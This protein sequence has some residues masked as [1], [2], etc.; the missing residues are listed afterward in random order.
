MSSLLAKIHARRAELIAAGK[1]SP[2]EQPEVERVYP[3]V[4]P[5]VPLR[6]DGQ[7]GYVYAQRPRMKPSRAREFRPPFVLSE[8]TRSGISSV[9][10][11]VAAAHGVTVAEI[12]A[13]GKMKLVSAARNDAI[14]AVAAAYPGLSMS[15][16]GRIFNGRD[17]STIMCAL[18]RVKSRAKGGA[19]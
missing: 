2:G 19:E 1:L 14:R 9:I 17:H 6:D 7:G 13:R 11:D 3:R 15:A 5:L 18:G 8:K 10:D 12:M 16:I 4:E